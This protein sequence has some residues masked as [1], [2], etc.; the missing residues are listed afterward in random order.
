MDNMK[1]MFFFSDRT[2][3]IIKKF[4]YAELTMGNQLIAYFYVLNDTTKKVCLNI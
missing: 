2:L 1:K 4:D 3:K